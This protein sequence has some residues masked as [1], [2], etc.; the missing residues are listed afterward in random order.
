MSNIADVRLGWSPSVSSD[1]VEQ[2]VKLTVDGLPREIT[3]TREVSELMIQV[4]AS[5]GVQFS[6]TSVDS[7]GNETAS[8][9]YTFAL[10]D[11][12]PPQPAT[13]LFH[14]VVAVRDADALPAE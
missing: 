13:G 9:I 6:V 4:E 10:G 1:V 2:L 12:V 14:E 5:T 3:L 7:E 8:E 11:L